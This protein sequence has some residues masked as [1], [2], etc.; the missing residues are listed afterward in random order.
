M[1]TGGG[2]ARMRY[3]RGEA[4]R[5]AAVLAAAVL[6]LAACSGSGGDSGSGDGA[7]SG[8][9]GGASGGQVASASGQGGTATGSTSKQSASTPGCPAGGPRP[10][11]PTVKADVDGDGAPDTLYLADQ[12]V[13]VL[14]ARGTG[15]RLRIGGAKPPHLLGGVDADSDGRAEVFVEQ[16]VGVRGQPAPVVTLAVFTGCKLAWVTNIQNERYQFLIQSFPDKG[17]GM[18]CVDANGDG[19]RDL[20][21]LAYTRGG[22]TVRW[23][24]TIVRINGTRATNGA[25]TRGTFTSPR[26]ESRI[27]SLGVATCGNND[28]SHAIGG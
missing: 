28:F 12:D 6:L 18:G 8:S 13:G 3:R 2:E 27:A 5:L 26:D 9:G 7:A 4:A 19:R 15:S 14:T 11:G 22:S 17:D 25:I 23:T 21:G 16:T 10:S 24:R 1:T 20:V